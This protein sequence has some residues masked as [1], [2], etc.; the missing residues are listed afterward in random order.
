M[1][2]LPQMVRVRLLPLAVLYY[3]KAFRLSGA[4]SDM[5]AP[6][7]DIIEV[8]LHQLKP[9]DWVVLFIDDDDEGIT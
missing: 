4:L 3:L 1:P 7:E 2:S 8:S 5:L 6:M 9:T